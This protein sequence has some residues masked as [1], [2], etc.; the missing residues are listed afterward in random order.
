MKQNFI[1]DSDWGGDVYQL[2]SILLARPEE[3]Q[4]LAATV[5]FGNASHDQNLANAGAL[6]RLLKADDKIP[7]FGGHKV[8]LG[9]E[10]QPQGDGAHGTSG[11]GQVKLPLSEYAP[12]EQHAVDHILE[13]VAREPEGSIT[14]I[15][16]GPQSNIAD[17]IARDKNTMS[18][19]KEI[20]IMGGCLNPIQGYRLD[21]NWNRAS[22][23]RIDLFGNITEHAE[24]NFQQDP[25][26][27]QVVLNS[28][29]PIKLFPMDCTHQLTFTMERQSRLMQ[30]LMNA[31]MIELATRGLIDAP[32]DMD[33]PKF[34]SASVMHDITTTISIVRP[35]LYTGSRG[36]VT[37]NT[38]TQ[39]PEFGRTTF[40]PDETGNVWAARTITDPDA[41]FTETISAFS[42]VFS[43]ELQP[44]VT[45]KLMR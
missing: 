15:A 37:V 13:T 26:S 19:L 40:V 28:G 45:H 10:D 22:E 35:D 41:A 11:L 39:S 27:A 12:S 8:P 25:A 36:R 32:R 21:E 20:R 16:T 14:L 7:V 1:I 24:F 6:L 17:A 31:P 3:F 34:G 29:I 44:K 30:A 42:T 5:V 43:Q 2:T 9:Q 38:D 18:R 4:I 23:N 33:G